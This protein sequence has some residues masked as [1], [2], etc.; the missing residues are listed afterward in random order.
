M[1]VK[2]QRHDYSLVFSSEGKRIDFR[3]RTVVEALALAERLLKQGQRVTLFQDG[4]ALGR[5]SYTPGGYWTVS[6]EA[7]GLENRGAAVQVDMV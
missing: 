1:T 6:H 5:V 3:A 4:E 2:C 7:A